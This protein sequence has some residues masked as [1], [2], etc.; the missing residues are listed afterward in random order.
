[1]D[2]IEPDW[3]VNGTRGNDLKLIISDRIKPDLDVKANSS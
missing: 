3:N 1:M 2:R